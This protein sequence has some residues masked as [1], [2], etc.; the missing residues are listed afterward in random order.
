MLFGKTGEM[1]SWAMCMLYSLLGCGALVGDEGV[2]GRESGSVE[3]TRSVCTPSVLPVGQGGPPMVRG[4]DPISIGVPQ[5]AST[6]G[7][8]EGSNKHLSHTRL[9]PLALGVFGLN[10]PKV[11]LQAEKAGLNQRCC[12]VCG[13]SFAEATGV[14][15]EGAR[16]WHA[17]PS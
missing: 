14:V 16:L 10:G 1:F 17:V 6:G 9:R 15:V 8:K 2:E 13:A 5:L 3:S 4:V 12:Q 7:R 11:L